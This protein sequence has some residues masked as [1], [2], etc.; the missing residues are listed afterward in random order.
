MCA[1]DLDNKLPFLLK[2]SLH[3]SI[4]KSIPVVDIVKGWKDVITSIGQDVVP[5]GSH[6]NPLTVLT[7]DSYYMAEDS[8]LCLEEP[9]ADNKRVKFTASVAAQR[10]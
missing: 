7:M 1:S 8:R 4:D 6:P 2:L 3:N 9:C 5:A 10:T